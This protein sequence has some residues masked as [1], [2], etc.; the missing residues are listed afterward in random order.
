MLINGKRALSYIVKIDDIKPIY[1]ADNISLAYVMGWRVIVKND[2]F[3]IGDKA[4][5]FEIDSKVPSDDIRFEFLAKRKFAIKTMKLNK[6]GV[7]S[8]GLLMP[9]SVFPELSNAEVGTDVT[10]ILKIKYYVAEDNERKASAPNKNAKYTSMVARHQNFSKKKWFKWMMKREWGRKFLFFFLGKK[11]D[12]PRAF[13]SKFSYIHKTD[14][15]R[16]ENQP[17]R[18]ESNEKWLATEKLDGTSSTYILERK[19]HKKFEFYVCSRNV[20]QQ[21]EKQACYHD[22]NIYWDMAFKYNIEAHLRQ[23]LSDN[24]NL[25]YVCI[26][27]ESVGSVQGNPLKLSEDDLYIFNF[28]TSMSGRLSTLAGKE[29]VE[30]WGMKWVPVLGIVDLPT[31]MDKMKELA[32]GKSAVNPSVLREGIVYRSLDGKQS[33]KNVSNEYL[34]RHS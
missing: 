27:G 9:L 1:G 14:E 18:L 13:P 25:T 7:I 28:I 33:F 6:F 3:N 34:M 10:D 22:H 21:D 11:K 15:D 17:W 8:Q 29:I 2:E 30:Q 20:R 26:Q 24:P 16:I 12:S 32:T 4:V 23:Y 19:P 5:F 31:T